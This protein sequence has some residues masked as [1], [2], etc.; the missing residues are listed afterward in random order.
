MKFTAIISFIALAASASAAYGEQ[1]PGGLTKGLGIA[2]KANDVRELSFTDAEEQE[3]GKQ[4]SAKIRA[5]YGVV[6]DANVHRYVSLVGLAM[7]QGSPRPALPWT[8]IVLDTDAVNAFA[9]PHGYVHITRGALALMRDESELAGVLAHE[10]G[11]VVKRHGVEKLQRHLRTGSLVNV[12]YS[13]ILGGEPEM[14]N[15]NALR[16]AGFLWTANHSREDEEEADKLA[17]EYLA[18]AGVDPRG[19]LTLLESLLEVEEADST[20]YASAWFSSHPLT[21]DRIQHTEAV[22]REDLAQVQQVEN[23]PEMRFASY[24]AFLRLVA[25]LPPA[26]DAGLR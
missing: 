16:L 11:H 13:I 20:T 4:V 10:I 21:A 7:A 15:Q 19:M 25:A 2:K 8:F 17:V 12:L 1:L 14:L 18:R 3:L 5:R 24:P 9:A 6:Q 23:A 26:P 22:I